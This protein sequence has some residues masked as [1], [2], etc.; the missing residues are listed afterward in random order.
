MKVIATIEE[1]RQ[2][3]ASDRRL[4]RTIG[5]VPTLGYLHEGHLQ[6]VQTARL[7]NDV[8]VVSI[9]VN[10]LLLGEDENFVAHARDLPRDCKALESIQI[11]Y[12]FAPALAEMYPQPVQTFVEAPILDTRLKS[13][14]HPNYFRGVATEMTKLFNIV[15]PT[16]AYFGEND[17][18][19]V[20][21]AR[22]LTQDFGLRIEIIS[23]PTVRESDGLVMSSKNLYLTSQERQAALCLHQALKEACRCLK[24]KNVHTPRDLEA[25]LAQYI[26]QEPLAKIELIAVRDAETMQDMPYEFP[27]RVFILLFVRFGRTRLFD[28]IVIDLRSLDTD[29]TI[30]SK[31]CNSE[32]R[33]GGMLGGEHISAQKEMGH[34]AIELEDI[35]EF[36]Y[37][38][39]NIVVKRISSK[40]ER[41]IYPDV[42]S[43]ARVEGALI[44]EHPPRTPSDPMQLLELLDKF[45][46]EASP[47][48]VH[49]GV[50]SWV[51]A[52]PLPLCGLLT[53][54]L[55]SLGVFPY[56]W[57]LTPGSIQ[58][59]L[60]VGRWL[61]QMVGFDD[62]A[63]GYVT[64]GGT[65]ANLY[66]LAAARGE[67]AGWDI[68]KQGVRSGP[69]LIV[70]ASEQVHICIE[71]S[72][73]L[74]GLGT[75]QLRRIP[76]DASFS[77][78]VDELK[79]V[80]EDDIRAGFKPLCVVGTAGTT[81]T[82]AIDPLNDIANIAAHFGIW[83]HI[84]GSYGA[85][86]ALD[87]S[88]QHLLHGIDR[89]SSLAVD[90][91]KWL[92]IPFEAGCILM[93]DKEALARAFT[94]VPS[95]LQGVDSDSGHDHWH[96]GFE[97]ARADRAT[98]IWLA[99][100]QYGLDAYSAMITEHNQFA[101]RLYE[102][103]HADTEFEPIHP[104]FLS[105]LCFRY[106]IEGMDSNVVDELNRQVESELRSRGSV[107]VTSA[108]LRHRPVLR[109]C[110]VN[111]RTTWS[112]VLSAIEQV[113]KI[114]RSFTEYQSEV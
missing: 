75:D 22:R 29:T 64:T 101:Q 28:Q 62:K 85:L 45:L 43:S 41:P 59:E 108:V 30:A 51:T 53:G 65:M 38:V 20:L 44:S 106:A 105:A 8:V 47:N 2:T 17:Y 36:G 96:Y 25:H 1:L 68:R 86:A 54:L 35:R 10:P 49:P 84:D 94:C 93:K 21:L 14:F 24:L 92:N 19:K 60:A 63:F 61:G 73:A 107:M 3:L 76:V 87:K 32:P 70:Y 88:K 37:R 13:A 56:A 40:R 5:F 113:R 112:D 111:H 58:L 91:H 4:E 81:L 48:F 97:L 16:R 71:Q 104:P 6:L 74:L 55:S 80:I 11:D 66:G 82:G 100:S 78:Q 31:A 26:A 98:K 50:M 57:R 42:Q 83:Y 9:F 27:Q 34:L 89:A 95:Y 46:I 12:V 79:R 23:V 7:Q 33:V 39:T 18:Q 103:L 15:S 102:M 110:F 99:L 69:P 72:M 67:V 77:M 90:P 52:T 114:G 109:T